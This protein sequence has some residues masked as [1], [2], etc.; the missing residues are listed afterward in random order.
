M[1]NDKHGKSLTPTTPTLRRID[2]LYVTTRVNLQMGP[3]VAF[4]VAVVGVGKLGTAARFLSFRPHVLIGQYAFGCYLSYSIVLGL[5]GTWLVSPLE[6]MQRSTL[7][8][9]LVVGISCT[10][11]GTY[12]TYVVSES[13]FL[14]IQSNH[15][16]KGISCKLALMI[17]VWRPKQNTNDS[18]SQISG[19]SR[20][21]RSRKS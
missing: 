8:V 12:N 13:P 7:L 2:G 17:L 21:V 9:L 19:V 14:K 4:W 16:S 18:D 3:A 15:N 11:I 10:L 5:V 20:I 1:L 6:M